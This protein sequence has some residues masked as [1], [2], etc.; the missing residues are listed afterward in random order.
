MKKKGFTLIELLVVI[1]IIA[2]LASMLLPALKQ[3][4]EKAGDITCKG[5]LKQFGIAKV[6]YL[7]EYDFYL[8]QVCAVAGG[9]PRW[10][11]N[12]P[13]QKYV[14]CESQ[15]GPAYYD[16]PANTEPVYPKEGTT[17]WTCPTSRNYVMN[18]PW[19]SNGCLFSGY[20]LTYGMWLMGYLWNRDTCRYDSVLGYIG[21][22]FTEIKTPVKMPIMTDGNIYT[23]PLYADVKYITPYDPDCDVAY[24]H[25]E[26]FANVMYGD[27]HVDN[28]NQVERW[29]SGW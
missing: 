26:K 19:D 10:Y 22:K 18:Y 20:C 13:L 7:N 23:A 2:I 24:R 17:I 9:H 1:A 11:E 15:P 4:K 28:T 27:A 14:N 5:N 16:S 12:V 25:Q 29:W 6:M 8:P 3:A 21:L